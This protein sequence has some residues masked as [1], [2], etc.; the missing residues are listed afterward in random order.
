MDAMEPRLKERMDDIETRL[1]KRMDGIETRINTRITTLENEMNKQ[2][3]KFESFAQNTRARAKNSRAREL[4]VPYTPLVEEDGAAIRDF[5]CT[6]NEVNAL[7][8]PRLSTLL[9]AV[10]VE[11]EDGWTVEQKRSAFLS[12]IGVMRVPTFP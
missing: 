12:A 11:L 1:N 6:F 5:P 9:S 10:G 4:G 2:F 7:A 3:V 8:E